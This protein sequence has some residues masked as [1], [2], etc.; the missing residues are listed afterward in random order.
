[1]MGSAA[2]AGAQTLPSRTRP[3]RGTTPLEGLGTAER[4]LSCAND[5]DSSYARLPM[6]SPLPPTHLRRGALAIAAEEAEE[7]R[8]DDAHL[9]DAD[10]GA[11]QAKKKKAKRDEPTPMAK[12]VLAAS[13]FF[14][15]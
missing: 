7:Q 11:S 2:K 8:D 15:C 12:C 6:D 1:M 4:G 9:Q 14:G 10:E 3:P 5:A 13:P